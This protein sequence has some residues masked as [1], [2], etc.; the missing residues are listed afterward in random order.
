MCLRD[1]I[2]T[3][4]LNT[5]VVLLSTAFLSSCLSFICLFIFF[6]NDTA[7]TEIYTLSLHDALPIS[8]RL[9]MTNSHFVNSTGLPDPQHY[10]T[11]RDLGLLAAAII[12]DF[13]EYYPLY[14]LKEYTYNGITQPNRNRLLWQDPYV[15]GMKTGHT[16]SAGY[17]LISSARRGPMR[18]ISVVLGTAS[19]NVRTAE[20]QQLLNYG[21]QFYE[22]QRIYQKGQAIATLP[23]WKGGQNTVKAGLAQDLYLTLPRGQYAQVKA[24]LVTRQPLLA[25]LNGG[26]DAVGTLKLTL[27]GKPLAEYPLLALETVP[28]AGIFGRAW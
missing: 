12:R 20:S 6:F 2:Y 24:S 21:F 27:D 9:G 14:S 22:T 7:T 25:P 10:T 8:Q 3:N 26:R 17:C 23:V 4:M 11:A 28:V 16:E 19:D 5:H 15:D 13:P 18:L 1:S